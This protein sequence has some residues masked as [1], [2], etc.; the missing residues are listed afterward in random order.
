MKQL[1]PITI[2]LC[3]I[4]LCLYAQVQTPKYVQMTGT[5]KGYYEYLPQGYNS[6]SETYPLILFITGIA[7]FGDG[8]PAQLPAVLKNGIPKLINNG[9][10]PTSFTVNGQ[11]FKFIII[12][13]QF[14]KDPKPNANDVDSVLNF[15]VAHY[16]VNT[17]RI[18]ITGLS[19]GGGV[20]WAYS[21][22]NSYYASRIAAIVPVASATAKDSIYKR[23]RVIAAANLPVWATH[24][25]YD[26]D[27][28]VAD[29]LEYINDINLDPAPN[30]KA[31]I[32]T[33]PSAFHDAW[34]RTYD[35]NFRE[36]GL[37]I[38]EWMLQYQLGVP[39]PPP[40][41]DTTGYIKV[42]IYGGTNPYNNPHWNDWNLTTAHVTNINSGAFKFADGTTSTI[43]ATLSE[44]RGI[45][46][47]TF[48]Y[49]GGIAPVQVLRYDTWATAPRT[50][51]LNGLS[52]AQT[53]TVELYASSRRTGNS[54]IFK[55]N[56]VSDTI[57]T[58]SNYLVKA[59]F[60]GL[61][62]NN[63]GQIVVNISNLNS[64]NYLNGFLIYLEN[65]TVTDI[66]S[67]PGQDSTIIISLYPNPAKDQCVL[68]LDNKYRGA[69]MI[70]VI[71]MMGKVAKEYNEVKN[72]QVVQYKLH[73]PEL[74]T[75]I[76][77]IKVQTGNKIS[78]IKMIKY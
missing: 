36:D 38:Y 41:N 66:T 2:C 27:T 47:N 46:D 1:L 18:Y 17:N 19:Y 6:G 39:H 34:T 30:P 23:S 42:N 60:N 3:F 33:F 73:I 25:S 12:T 78:S 45:N 64:F 49:G 9:T 76:Y 44:S 31:R 67:P 20:V 58:D 7:E 55:I 57:K 22:G 56:D 54:T 29:I 48:Y 62:P 24:N 77:I 11:T 50:L 28:P 68:N 72:Q 52:G 32:T 4:P 70:Q 51:T 35:P 21:G 5:V 8:S 69:L 10:F 43:S 63:Q 59:A 14:K 13:P 16:R 26:T 40:V 75:G 74:N 37:N 53:Y 61:S 65:N 15:I 71:D